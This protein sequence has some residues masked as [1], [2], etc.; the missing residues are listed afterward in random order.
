M[1][2]TASLSKAY[3]HP[4]FTPEPLARVEDDDPDTFILPL[5]RRQ[6]KTPVEGVDTLAAPTITSASRPATSTAADEPSSW[7]SCSG[8]STARGAA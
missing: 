5:R 2:Q 1:S 4:G 3:R 8:G 6:K 7:S